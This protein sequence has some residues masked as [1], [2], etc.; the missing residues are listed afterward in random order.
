MYILSMKR[1][2]FWHGAE[3]DIS[4]CVDVA[5]DVCFQGRVVV[6]HGVTKV[7]HVLSL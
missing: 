5:G 7:L 3:D 6:V 2:Y 1:R 4:L